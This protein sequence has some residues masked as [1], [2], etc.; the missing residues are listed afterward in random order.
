MAV[1][2]YDWLMTNEMERQEEDLLAEELGL[3]N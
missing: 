2:K 3:D 1:D